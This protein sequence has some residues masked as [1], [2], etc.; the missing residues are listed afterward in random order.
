[1]ADDASGGASGGGGGLLADFKQHKATWIGVGIAA[2][3]LVVGFLL[4]LRGQTSSQSPASSSV[5]PLAGSGSTNPATPGDMASA[6][7]NLIAMISA[8]NAQTQQEIAAL[9]Q[10]QTSASSASSTAAQTPLT[11]APLLGLASPPA[12]WTGPV[13]H[14]VP[15]QPVG[16]TSSWGG[17]EGVMPIQ[18]A[19]APSAPVVALG[20]SP[21]GT[22]AHFLTAPSGYAQHEFA[23]QSQLAALRGAP[24]QPYRLV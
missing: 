9:Q 20:A 14:P 17:P 4:Y 21:L 7:G 16:A 22:G 24:R 1:M 5:F 6:L 13:R 12:G 2:A 18:P 15:V 8:Q 11:T 19:W 23:P 10:Q 3:T